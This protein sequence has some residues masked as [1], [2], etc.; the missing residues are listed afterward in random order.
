MVAPFILSVCLKSFVLLFWTA[1]YGIVF[2]RQRLSSSELVLYLGSGLFFAVL[3]VGA[4][5]L[6]FFALILFLIYISAILILFLFA[7]LL[8]PLD[9]PI[10]LY[11]STVLTDKNNFPDAISLTALIA[12][13]HMAERVN[14]LRLYKFAFGQSSP[15]PA[16]TYFVD[17]GADE[18]TIHWL[19][20]CNYLAH[21]T[22][23][24]TLTLPRDSRHLAHLLYVDNYLTL[25]LVAIIMVLVMV[26]SL[27]WLRATT[28][29]LS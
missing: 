18:Q 21:Q 26:G 6:E 13:S 25:G 2:H 14:N 20:I 24:M 7:F 12:V 19:T 15:S 22:S 23:L 11:T 29:R 10:S 8:L 4:S 16:L 3:F 5:G 27:G 17:M 9:Q 1:F 28:L